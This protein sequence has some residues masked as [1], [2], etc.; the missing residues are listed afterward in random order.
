VAAVFA[1]PSV[2]QAADKPPGTSTNLNTSSAS[3]TITTGN[4]RK[5]ARTFRYTHAGGDPLVVGGV[6]GK[7]AVKTA[8]ASRALRLA[9]KRQG[10]SPAAINALIK[11]AADPK[12][13][14]GCLLKYGQIVRSM[15]SHA[16]DPKVVL[17]AQ[18][19][20]PRYKG[21]RGAWSYCLHANF[22]LHSKTTYGPWKK[23]SVETMDDG[24][25]A[26]K[27]RRD[28]TTA[29]A[30]QF[31]GI[32]IMQICG[33]V[34]PIEFGKTSEAKVEQ[35]FRIVMIPAPKKPKP[36]P[37]PAPTPSPTPTPNPA[38]TP[39]PSPSCEILKANVADDR[40][41]VTLVVSYTGIPT[42]ASS[43][44]WG[45]KTPLTPFSTT[46][47]N[48]HTF[49]TD[50]STEIVLTLVSG[51]G[52]KDVTCN[53]VWQAP[54]IVV[55]VPQHECSVS[56]TVNGTNV[57]LDIDAGGPTKG[58]PSIT[59]EPN[60]TNTVPYYDYD[61]P[62][63]KD[64]NVHTEYSDGSPPSDCPT[65]VNI[66]CPPPVI[67]K[68]GEQKDDNGKCIPC[69]P[70]PPKCDGDNNKDQGNQNSNNDRDNHDGGNRDGGGDN[71]A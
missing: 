37:T 10:A 58:D 18:F 43:I 12:N 35:E 27:Q 44:N 9:M 25:R 70:P 31:V 7:T 53:T 71:N 32:Q 29:S 28:V 24:S 5:N 52:V 3:V 20:D 19:L 38:P 59:W 23:V 48:T 55:A 42:S 34:F 4:G 36:V 67:C 21:T 8:V 22:N 16:A 62:G 41:T 17:N 54:P 65:T 46:T 14:T 61:T 66:E 47:P 63:P 49:N 13:I 51:G 64:I 33:N 50:S 45:D 1:I 60:V 11:A 30:G 56:A 26:I 15:S 6:H 57:Y 40:H 69:P 39:T 2:A 68:D